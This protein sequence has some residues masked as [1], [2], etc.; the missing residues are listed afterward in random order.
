MADAINQKNVLRSGFAHPV[1][2]SWQ[3]VNPIAANGRQSGGREKI[4]LIH[5]I[6]ALGLAYRN[7]GCVL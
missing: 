7:T 3:G 5:R 4:P 6:L 1:T 2:R